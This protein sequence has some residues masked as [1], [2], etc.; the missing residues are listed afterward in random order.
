MRPTIARFSQ[1]SS[2][3]ATIIE[4][5]TPLAMRSSQTRSSACSAL[6]ARNTDR[7]RYRV[8]DPHVAVADVNATRSCDF[9]FGPVFVEIGFT[10]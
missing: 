8:P 10:D 1:P 6:D 2:R 9:E 5:A 3:I 4:T 7:P